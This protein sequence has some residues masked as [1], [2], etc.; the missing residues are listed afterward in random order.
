MI[1]ARL[2][3]VGLLTFSAFG[4]NFRGNLAGIATDASGAALPGATLQLNSPSTGLTLSATSSANGDYLFVDLPVGL[5][6]LT[7]S[8]A[9]FQ[10]KKIDN[11]E[12]AI[13][14]TTNLNI[15]V[16]VAQQQSAVEVSASAV[17]VDTTSSSLTAVVNTSTVQDL[18]MNGRD[19][20]QMIKMVPGASPAATTING[21]RTNGNNYQIDGADN[22]DGFQNASAVNQGGVSGIAGTLLPIEAID[23]FAVESSGGPEQGRNGGAQINVVLK[24]GTND[25]HGSLFYFNRNEALAAR[26]PF[27]LATQPKQVIRNN[28][29]GFSGGGPIIKDK[30][31]FFLAGEGQLAIADNSILTTEPSA[32]WVTAAQG[33]LAK[34]NVPVNPVSLNLLTIF[35]ANVRTGP[36][37]ANNYL[38]NGQNNYNSYNGVLKIDHRFNANHS[39]F[40]RYYVGT[41]TQ[42]ADIGSHIAGFFQVAPSHMHNIAVAETAILSPR[43]VNVL[44]LGVNYFYQSF[45]D[46]ETGVNPLALGLNTGVTSPV[47]QGSP[48]IKITGFDYVGATS[49]EARTDTTGHL[50][51]T[52]SYNLGRHAFGFGGEFRRAVEDVGYDINQRG[53]FTF[54]G[55]RGPWS[56][57]P[58]AKGDLGNLADFLAG[59]PSNSNGAT[60]VQ[61]PLQRLYYQDSFDLWAG[62]TF[63][64]TPR[65]T[66]NYGARYTYQGVLHDSKNTITNFIPGRGFVTPGVG[67]AGPLYPQDWRDL[68]P[69]F[70]FAY[71]PFAD[72]K[73]VIRGGYGIFYDVPALNF[74]TA[75]TSLSNSGAAGVNANPGGANPVYTLS[76]KNVIFAPGAPIFGSASPTPPFGVFAVS[77]NFRTPYVQN[78]NLNIQRQLSQSTILQVGYVGSLGRKLPV[79][80]DIN[81][82]VV[83]SGVA[84]RPYAVQYPTLATIDEAETVANS[85]YSSLQASLR[86]RVWRGLSATLN[87]TYGH[88]LDD[89]S[90]SRNTIPTDSYN[91]KDQRGSS[92]FD[93]RHMVTSFVSY[94]APQFVKSAPRLTKGWQFNSLFTFTTGQPINLLAGTNVSGTGENQD[95][96]DIVGNPF[97]NIPTAT[98]PAVQYFN[99]AAFAKPAAGTFGDIGRDAY[100]GP[101]IGTVDFSVFKRTPITERIST[102]FRVEIFNL[103]N[104][105]NY[106]N[107]NVT[108]SSSSFGQLTQ[109]FSNSSA[110]GL[111]FAEPRN[112]QL[113]L[114][115]IW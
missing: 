52:L 84:V 101:G 34:Y 47:L 94:E 51:D 17:S 102:E 73:T 2:A 76:V 99:P 105:T 3:L 11:V 95:R 35:P 42:T 4:Q 29:F 68:A 21:M 71:T 37:T 78:F 97:A 7:V 82:P 63:R 18:P 59:Y 85:D 60:I 38:S 96:V 14:K 58:T 107:P 77:Q 65:F 92:T 44:T 83:T 25:F 48:S 113:A 93:I 8:A 111:G 74:L 1:L 43:L 6:T 66:L 70:G 19:F 62:D 26:S 12:I 27:L 13:S 49:P 46:A 112:T 79:L 114:K 90:A 87:Y 30:T 15:Q 108:F 40:A 81:Q 100:Y 69:R 75:N 86:Q 88:A 67:A 41:G 56:T 20:R 57:D 61:G 36:A 9:G 106:A 115:V 53:T 80:L 32:A 22:N 89:T 24:S 55:T 28:Q 103:F 110:P 5:Y 50:T 64:I 109:T 45:N 39:M 98:A 104:R 31:F 72:G 91:L 23:Q 33:L 10:T 16:A 54:D